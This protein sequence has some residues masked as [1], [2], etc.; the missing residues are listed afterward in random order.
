MSTKT[1]FVT[2]ANKGIGFETAKAL[3]KYGFRVLIGARDE[4]RGTAAVEALAEFGDV[5]LQLI[6]MADL[7]SIRAAVSNV[8]ENYADLTLLIN[9]AGI[10]GAFD[11]TAWD[12]EA[13]ELIDTYMVDFIGPFGL[14][15][16]LLP[17]LNDNKG[18]VVNITIP[19]EAHEF[20][21]P[22]AYQAAKAP[23]NVMIDNFG[24]EVAQKNMPVQIMGIMP[25]AVS[26]DLNDHAQGDFV[27]TP[28]EAAEQIV[29][30]ATDAKNY[31][32]KIV[33]VDNPED[34]LSRMD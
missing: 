13:Q 18:K 3:L 1:A 33:N 2:G 22:F 32:G 24:L 14:T 17:L 28:T 8:K 34:I 26:T 21:H 15:K 30:I 20:F 11:K 10:S 6:D 31:N 19:T 29:A 25:G 16:G 7:D 27:K 4:S 23:L 9:N 5:Q 12:F